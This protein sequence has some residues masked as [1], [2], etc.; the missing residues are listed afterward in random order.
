MASAAFCWRCPCL[1]SVM[2][3]LHSKR[4]QIEIRMGVSAGFFLKPSFFGAQELFDG[5]S[6]P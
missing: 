1:Q 3:A 5:F 2:L 6:N 4:D